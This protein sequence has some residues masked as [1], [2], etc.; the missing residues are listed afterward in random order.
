MSHKLASEGNSQLI[1]HNSSLLRFILLHHKVVDDE[2][3][4]FHGVLAHV[5]LEEAHHGIVLVEADTL[6]TDVLA[7]EVLELVG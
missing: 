5:E 6:E 3:L 2:V 7:D 4:A 1:T